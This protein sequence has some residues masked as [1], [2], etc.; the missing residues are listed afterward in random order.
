MQQVKITSKNEHQNQIL[1]YMRNH[2]TINKISDKL[3]VSRLM[4]T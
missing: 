3:T 2:L 1:R 4:E